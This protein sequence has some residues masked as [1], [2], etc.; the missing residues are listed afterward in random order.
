M[1][2]KLSKL[3]K[4]KPVLSLPTKPIYSMSKRKEEGEKEKGDKK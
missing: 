1:I 4:Y 3:F 2:V